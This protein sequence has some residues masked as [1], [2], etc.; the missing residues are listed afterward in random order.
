MPVK[1]FMQRLNKN[2]GSSLAWLGVGLLICVG[3]VGLSLGNFHNPGPGFLPFLCGAV[4]AGLS[5]ID[6]FQFR[7]SSSPEQGTSPV[8]ADRKKG[9]KMV[10]TVIALL[11]YA[12]GMQ[13]LGFLWSTMI[14]IGFLLRVIE[15][16][17]WSVVILSSLLTAV[18]SYCIF[19]LWLQTQLPKGPFQFF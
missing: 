5:F 19:E 4:L 7:R 3:S 13:Y 10:W 12:V 15:P 17:R 11:A 16:K 9:M 18:I 14:F 2:Q 6:F 1:I 8:W